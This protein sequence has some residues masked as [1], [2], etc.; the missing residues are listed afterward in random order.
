MLLALSSSQRK[1]RTGSALSTLPLRYR[2]SSW[3]LG[4][5]GIGSCWTG[6]VGILGTSKRADE[7][8]SG[9]KIPKGYMPF[10][11]VTLGY[12]AFES[13]EAPPRKEGA[14]TIL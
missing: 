14:V 5:L 1:N 10:F 4:S 3:P 8:A 9:P 11:G 12:S 2:T 7:F 13:L 6:T